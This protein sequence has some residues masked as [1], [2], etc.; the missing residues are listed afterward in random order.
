MLLILLWLWN[1]GISWL[2]AWGCGKSWTETKYF[3]G[4]AHF[5]NWMAA[6]MS[7]CG[8]TWCYAV[9]ACLVGGNVHHHVGGKY[10]PYL[11]P[12]QVSAVLQAGYLLIILP[13]L[14]SGLAITIHSW[15]VWKRNRGMRNAAI[16]G[17]NTF[18][19]IYNTYEA[20][21][22]VPSASRGVWKFFDS[23]DKGKGIVLLIVVAAALG[24][25][26]T[27]YTII[28]AVARRTRIARSLSYDRIKA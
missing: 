2:N 11:S 24:G 28:T 20:I 22:T 6:I 18:A 12:E 15:V 8:F 4:V 1:F 14:G 3:G 21:R 7:A 27:T 13:I 17:Y 19:D 26:L 25:I 5:M 16:A 10:V 9:L 23:D